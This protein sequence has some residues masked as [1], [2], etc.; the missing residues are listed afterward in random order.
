M[1]AIFRGKSTRPG[2]SPQHAGR[3][4]SRRGLDRGGQTDWPV[5]FA[6]KA[7]TTLL[8]D[9]GAALSPFNAFQ[10][11]KVETLACGSAHSENAAR[12]ADFWPTT[13]GHARH[14]S[15]PT[16]GVA[17]P[18]GYHLTVVTVVWSVSNWPKGRRRT[19][20]HRRFELFYHVA[21]IGDARS[22]A[23]HPATTTHSQLAPEE[24]APAGVAGLC[25]LVHRHRAYRRY[26]RRSGSGF[27]CWR[28]RVAAE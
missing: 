24:Q 8:R 9:L 20:L 14:L 16:R 13:R 2:N 23:I 5:A 17:D 3:F 11:I 25:A 7:R 27:D 10:I 21:N 6:I 28:Q 26:P 19:T 22:L 1:A 18:G 15:R 4:L 12:V